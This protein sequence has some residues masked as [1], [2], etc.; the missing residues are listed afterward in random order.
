MHPIQCIM[1]RC[2]I[3][4]LHRTITGPLSAFTDPEPRS[5]DPEPPSEDRRSRP[6]GFNHCFSHKVMSAKNYQIFK[7]YQ[8]FFQLRRPPF[9]YKRVMGPLP[10]WDN[11][12]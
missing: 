11:F 12:L 8:P 1:V 2:T 4:M 5:T 6:S 10:P 9:L 3:I 7:N